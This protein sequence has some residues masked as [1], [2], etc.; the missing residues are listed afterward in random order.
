MYMRCHRVC[1]TDTFDIYSRTSSDGP[2]MIGPSF[3]LDM[4]EQEFLERHD[5]CVENFIYLWS[6]E[7]D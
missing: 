7:F 6:I 3:L 5:D 2:F 4:D 1:A